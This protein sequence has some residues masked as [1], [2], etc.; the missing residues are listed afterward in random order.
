[1]L[2]KLSLRNARRSAKDYLVYMITMIIFAALMFAFNTMLFSRDVSLML[3]GVPLMAVMIGMATFFIILVIA[4]LIRYMVSFMLEKR[5]REFGIYMLIGMKKKQ[6][7]KLFFREN[8]IM[9]CLAF[10][11][12]LAFGFFLQQVLMTIFHSLVGVDYDLRLDLNPYSFLMTTGLYFGCYLLAL[13]R[14]KRK[15]RKMN[16]NYL[17]NVDKQ[18]QQVNEKGDRWKQ[19]LFFLSLIYIAVFYL[20]MFRGGYG[21]GEVILFI[22]GFIAAIYFIYLGLS[23]FVVR[24]IR[25]KRSG[26]YRSGNLFLLRQFSA[27]IKTMAFTMGT[28]TIL[29]AL[30]MVGLSIAMMFSDYLNKQIHRDFPFHISMSHENAV[31]D[32]ADEVALINE[33]VEINDLHSFAIYQ[34]GTNEMNVFLYTS[35]KLFKDKFKLP[36]GSPDREKI[37][38]EKG[39]YYKYDTFMKLSDYNYLRNMLGH[40]EVRLKE[41][42][43]LIQLSER[44]YQEVNDTMSNVGVFVAGEVFEFAGFQTI[45]FAQDGHNGADYVIV[46]P[47]AAIHMMVPYYGRMVMDIA[48]ERAMG[49]QDLLEPWFEIDEED[50]DEY[51]NESPGQVGIFD[52]GYSNRGYGTKQIIMYGSDILIRADVIQFLKYALNSIV[53]P[54]FYIAMVYLLVAL[55]V[56]SVQQLSDSSKY[57]FRYTVLSKLGLSRNEIDRMILKQLLWYYLCPIIIAMII[58]FVVI[59]FVSNIFVLNTGSNTMVGTYFAISMTMLFGIYALYFITT[60]ILFKR[61]CEL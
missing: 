41:Q 46:V 52:N 44:V 5:S 25:S 58:S 34:N 40:D 19:W 53:F 28:L 12:G 33:H 36:D 30:A 8:L 11:L 45:G 39:A 32:F 37:A 17:M 38:R 54:L 21:A 2:T 50:E 1:M 57:K 31:Y 18:N 10:L 20:L 13:W 47:D 49:L 61:G 16:I 23:S 6:I 9:G 42:Q 48:G 59:L 14:S 29:F 4:W 56:L 15:F 3:Q 43:Y 35:L 7:S 51:G 55:T 60:Y 27:K 24:Y 26:I 22:L